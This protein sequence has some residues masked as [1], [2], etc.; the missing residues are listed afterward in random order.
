MKQTR[1]TRQTEKDRVIFRVFADGEV[2]A[3]FPFIK[4]DDRGD[5]LSYLHIG[6][7]GP[8]SRDVVTIT[9]P[10]TRAEYTPLMRELRRLGYR[11]EVGKRLTRPT[12]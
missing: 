12:R 1:K 2:L 5:I 11:L 8:A 9:R 10:A 4:W 7:H 6:Q 3:L